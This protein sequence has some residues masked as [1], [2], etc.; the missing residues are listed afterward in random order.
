MTTRVIKPHHFGLL[1]GKKMT[2]KAGVAAAQPR[3]KE[4]KK[5]R[6]LWKYLPRH[7]FKIIQSVLKK[8]QALERLMS[9]KA[10]NFS[11]LWS[12]NSSKSTRKCFSGHNSPLASLFKSVN[13]S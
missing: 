6:G 12:H 13:G 4:W 3:V 2:L 5:H 8:S 11:W 7:I 1:D 9:K 10:F